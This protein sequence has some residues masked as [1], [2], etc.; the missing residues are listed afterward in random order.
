MKPSLF[1]LTTDA[2]ILDLIRKGDEEAL[3]MLY[4]SNRKPIVA[5]VS[6]NSGT[7]DDAEDLLQ[8]SL[9][10]LWER[11]RRGKFEYKAQLS[12]FIYATMKNL[13]SQ[14]LRGMKRLSSG[15]IDPNDHEDFSPSALDV[16]IESEHAA[17]V[18]DA[19]DRIGGQCRK[20]LLLFYW[21]EMS[22]DEIA[23]RLGFANADT[24]KAKKYQC[25][26]ALERALGSF[27]KQS[28]G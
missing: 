15:E 11:V 25:K 23:S 21:E 7:S 19:L 24:A 4:E 5:Y 18:R 8:E 16:L 3:V 6:R 17:M 20:L 22:M 13:W 28:E 12:T 27:Q 10:I 1:F 2:R 9:V 14:R 26:K